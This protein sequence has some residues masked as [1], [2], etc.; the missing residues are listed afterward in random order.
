MIQFFF[1][2]II[3]LITLFNIIFLYV[4]LYTYIKFR[5]PRKS[6]NIL[7]P[8]QKYSVVLVVSNEEKLIEGVL[9]SLLRQEN[10]LVTEIIVVVNNSQDN[11]FAIAS[12]LGDKIKLINIP[13][14]IGKSSALIKGLAEAN[15][16]KVFVV[17][18]DVLLSNKS[19]SKLAVFSEENQSDFTIGIIKYKEVTGW[20]S[21][22]MEIERY[23]IN[24]F[25]QVARGG[26]GVATI[27]G[28]FSLVN[29]DVYLQFL[30]DKILQEDLLVTYELIAKNIPI[31]TLNEVVAEESD[32][33][34][35][36]LL[37]LQRSRWIIGNT[38]IFNKLIYSV[39]KTSK[40]NSKIFLSSYPFLWYFIYYG[41]IVG[42]IVGLSNSLILYL[43]LFAH[44][45]YLSIT[46]YV[47]SNNKGIS[48][49]NLFFCFLHS[50]IF[51]VLITI[52][53][54]FAVVSIVLRI[55]T[56]NKLFFK[57]F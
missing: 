26:L 49:R 15:N 20:Q 55:N 36:G 1:Q 13:S 43:N 28:S 16:Q 9:L 52:S 45:T 18:A 25:L 42:Y 47:Y 38:K 57:R 46:T 48:F 19:L 39:I 54:L 22:I 30:K 35:F 3:G 51:P 17:D 33:S 7:R 14:F 32:R 2:L 27:H 56:F 21:K 53:A 8:K 40:I 5:S 34:T 44:L 41:F 6:S 11:T 12:S 31:I 10:I 4:H 37:I 29:K 50:L 24:S 23:F